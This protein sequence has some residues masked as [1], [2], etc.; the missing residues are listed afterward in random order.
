MRAAQDEWHIVAHSLLSDTRARMGDSMESA[1]IRHP[2]L[3]THSLGAATRIQPSA[4]R[5]RRAKNRARLTF[6]SSFQVHSLA[7]PCGSS[8]GHRFPY[9]GPASNH[10]R[11]TAFG[12]YM[13]RANCIPVQ[14]RMCARLRRP[15]ICCR[16]KCRAQRKPSAMPGFDS[17]EDRGCRGCTPTDRSLSENLPVRPDHGRVF[18]KVWIILNDLDRQWNAPP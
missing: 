12:G 18:A 17:P 16:R 13:P 5:S 4:D 11:K 6:W 8:P 10:G 7:T 3:C 1:T 15:P 2:P 14:S 9:S